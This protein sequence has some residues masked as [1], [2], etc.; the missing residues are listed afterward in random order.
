MHVHAFLKRLNNEERAC[1]NNSEL[2][3][4]SFPRGKIGVS[5]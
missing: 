5:I 1:G 2:A 4:L 3:M